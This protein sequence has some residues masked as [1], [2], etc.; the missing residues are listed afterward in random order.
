MAWFNVHLPIIIL[1]LKACFSLFFKVF[2]KLSDLFLDVGFLVLIK[3]FNL[4]F[5]LVE[6][7]LH[8]GK[9]SIIVF[10]NF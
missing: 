9:I 7:V 5:D 6:L 4:L 10:G 1:D 2:I 8:F 3:L